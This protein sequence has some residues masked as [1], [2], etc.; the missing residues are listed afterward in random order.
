MTVDVAHNM[1]ILKYLIATV[2]LFVVIGYFIIPAPLSYNRIVSVDD[3]TFDIPR[4]YL[5]RPYDNEDSIEMLS[6]NSFIFPEM[7]LTH[8]NSKDDVWF[9]VLSRVGALG[10]YYDYK[11]GFEAHFWRFLRTQSNKN[12][13]I[14]PKGLDKSSGKYLY[15]S[16][17]YVQSVSG[18]YF[19]YKQPIYTSSIKANYDDIINSH[20]FII[21][22]P[23]D[24]RPTCDSVLAY[25]NIYVDYSFD[26]TLL[27][28]ANNVKAA[29]IQLLKTWDVKTETQKK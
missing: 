14:V 10:N 1:R 3:V 24:P 2:I 17:E 15:I 26:Q 23:R 4:K 20:D 9:T 28:E 13:K 11:D 21:C 7:S 27:K 25:K 16:E 8:R 18:E 5:L 12:W 19:T 6:T 29:I 22:Y